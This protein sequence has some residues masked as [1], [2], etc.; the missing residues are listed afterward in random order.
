METIQS[1]QYDKFLSEEGIH[2]LT[3]EACGIGLRVLYDL[4]PDGVALIAEFL[5]TRILT[6]NSWN[7]QTSGSASIM[8]PGQ[9]IEPLV[10]YVMLR[11][12]RHVAVVHVKTKSYFLDSITGLQEDELE[13]WKERVGHTYAND[14]Y[15]IYSRQGTVA[16]GMRNQHVMSGRV[17]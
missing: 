4:A 8:L 14:E 6:G 15:R 13:E 16:N 12:Y 7:D 10:I 9:W 11:E 3:S 17:A 2:A 5:G 1:Y